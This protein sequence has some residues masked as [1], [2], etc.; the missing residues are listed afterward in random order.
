MNCCKQRLLLI[1]TPNV[2]LPLLSAECKLILNLPADFCEL[3]PVEVVIY[4]GGQRPMG[5][6][7]ETTRQVFEETWRLHAFGAFLWARQVVPDMLARGRGAILFTSVTA[8]IRGRLRR[9]SRRR[10]SRCADWR[11]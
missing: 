2:S 1:N 4:N 6:L 10:N 9:A 11:R 7:M 8:G 3:G 5:R